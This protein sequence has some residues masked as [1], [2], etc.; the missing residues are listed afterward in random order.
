[1]SIR[2]RTTAAALAAAIAMSASA[3]RASDQVATKLPNGLEG[4]SFEQRLGAQVP[5]DLRFRD[6]AGRERVL[7]ELVSTGRPV[8]LTLNYFECPLL[9]TVEL[10]GL[11]S[12]P[13]PLTLTPGRDFDV[14]TVS[15]NPA[16]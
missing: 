13:K 7:R 10:N 8:I 12:A 6:E 5:L 14:V 16:A 11:V 1:M 4:V 9:C 3:A 2:L 15:F